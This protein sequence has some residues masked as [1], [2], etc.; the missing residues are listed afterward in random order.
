MLTFK[1]AELNGSRGW[2]GVK[3]EWAREERDRERER[4][5]NENGSGWEAGWVGGGV[6]PTADSEHDP[7]YKFSLYSS[8]FL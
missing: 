5:R 6:L 4:E 2:A 8:S 1:F 7:D 3:R